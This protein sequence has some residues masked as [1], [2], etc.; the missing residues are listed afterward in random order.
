MAERNAPMKIHLDPGDS[1]LVP[2]AGS[3][4]V[5][6]GVGSTTKRDAIVVRVQTDEGIT[7]YGEAHP[8][9]ARAP[10]PA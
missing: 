1:P 10:S 3:K 8:A 4:T 6:M 2:L 5:T 9:A 7:G